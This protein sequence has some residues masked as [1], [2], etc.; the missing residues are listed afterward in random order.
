MRMAGERKNVPMK[1][2]YAT[3]AVLM[4]TAFL[5]PDAAHAAGTVSLTLSQPVQSVQ[6]GGR[7]TFGGT[8]SVI[9]GPDTLFLS[10]EVV[11]PT[12]GFGLVGFNTPTPAL[13]MLDDLLFVHDLPAQIS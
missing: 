13:L 5:W 2:R 7:L 10:G 12:P 3:L 6:P 9:G 1:S 4:V 11:E 8:L